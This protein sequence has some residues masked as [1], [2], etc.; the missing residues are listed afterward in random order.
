MRRLST[1]SSTFLVVLILLLLSACSQDA[2]NPTG[3]D[4]KN[5]SRVNPITFSSGPK[6]G[7]FRYFADSIVQILSLGPTRKAIA[8]VSNGSA[9]NLKLLNAGDVDMGIV[10]AGDGFLGRNG[11]LP[12][13]GILYDAARSMAPLYGAP[14]QLV[15]RDDSGITT[16][17]HLKGRVVAIG[18][19]DSGAALAAERFFRHIGIWETLDVRF[20]GY[21]QA[22]QAFL[23]EVVDAYWVLTGFPN[24]AILK[25]ASL[26]DI[27]LLDVH[28]DALRHDFY[29]VYPFYSKVVIPADTYA[30]QT[31]EV[32]TFQDTAM[33]CARWGLRADVVYDALKDVYSG[34]GLREM[35][36]AHKAAR[37][38][39]LENG[40]RGV[41]IPLHP[42]AYRFWKEQGVSIPHKLEP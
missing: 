33:W 38:M 23:D 8:V 36:V 27:R 35:A 3:K 40:I 1:V 14:A 39:S 13:D 42:G 21:S 19:P 4:A 34:P 25:S 24:D 7:T 26:V 6:G 29:A 28:L 31:R 37:A 41:S 22:A 10:Y 15:V 17:R 5:G 20:V 16:V 12:G 18:N 32:I 30:G 2:G 11:R 9:D